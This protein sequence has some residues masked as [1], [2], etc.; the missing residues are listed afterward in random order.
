MSENT[1]KRKKDE[2]DKPENTASQES[3]SLSRENSPSKPDETESTSEKAP[4]SER[5]AGT[6][7]KSADKPETKGEKLAREIADEAYG[8][9]P[10][11]ND[12]SN[13]IFMA[14]SSLTPD[15]NADSHIE[16]QSEK[17]QNAESSLSEKR[18]DERANAESQNE[19]KVEENPNAQ[20]FNESE[21]ATAKKVPTA[22]TTS[23]GING[24]N[25][26]AQTD[27]AGNS[28]ENAKDKDGAK[29]CDCKNGLSSSS[30]CDCEKG[31]SYNASSGGSSGGCD[32]KSGTNSGKSGNYASGSGSGLHD[33]SSSS[34]SGSSCD[35]GMNLSGSSSDSLSSIGSSGSG[36]SRDCKNDSHGNGSYA[37]GSHGNGS[38]G[39]NGTEKT[40]K[41][42]KSDGSGV[43][44]AV[45][46]VGIATLLIALAL[47]GGN[48][49][50]N[51]T[52]S[53]KGADEI[54]IGQ[55]VNFSLEISENADKFPAD[56]EVIWTIDGKQVKKS[57]IGDKDALSFEY[58]PEK[59]GESK[60]AVK[61]GEYGNLSKTRT[62]AVKNPLIT[63]KMDD[64]SVTYGDKIPE[65]TYKA[66][67]FLGSDTEESVN[68]SVTSAFMERKPVVGKYEIVATTKKP[69]N[70]DVVLKSGTLTV[71]PRKITIKSE[72]SKVYDGKTTCDNCLSDAVLG[73]LSEGDEVKLEGSL[74]FLDKNAGTNKTLSF[75]DVKLTGKDAGNYLLD[76][77]R[78]FGSI[79]PKT[80]VL[81]ELKAA[82][83][84]F[85][86]TTNVTFNSVGSLSGI[87]SGD[88]VT[89]GEIVAHFKDA[90]AGE[91]K[92]VIIS[93]I[94]LVGADAVNYVAD[95]NTEITANILG[96][97]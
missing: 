53:L 3:L 22:Q 5:S 75:K 50:A 77:S 12:D 16:K 25:A 11:K 17:R 7:Q 90:S 60:I 37:N 29:N 70:Y 10:P 21:N 72:I 15:V 55:S 71:I 84:V 4:N 88:K 2:A 44:M 49:L 54:R 73:N 97:N 93:E 82:D 83:K 43:F 62:V 89:I 34:G 74:S 18:N 87:I 24:E 67:G 66:T 9:N 41:A 92:P 48:S 1:D 30:G 52:A 28:G 23:A 46:L 31:S 58:K 63:V 51:A 39:K 42:K 40:K 38:Y 91:N 85:D 69:E 33:S 68:L 27:S 14:G 61:I 65:F 19:E 26:T 57:K 13:R 94:K 45:V 80:L 8:E 76:T 20:K 35:C 36:S 95:A 59:R 96:A 64:V 79:T 86:G 47:G 78:T 81:S 6:S 56:T 32:C